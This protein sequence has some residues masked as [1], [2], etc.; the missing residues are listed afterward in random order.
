MIEPAI[1]HPQKAAIEIL[2]DRLGLP[3]AQS[4][5]D[6]EFEVAE[7][8]ELPRYLALYQEVQGEDDLRFVLADIIIQAFEDS[9]FELSENVDWLTFLSFLA[10][11]IDIHGWQIWYWASWE[12]ELEDAWRV[13]PFMRALCETHFVD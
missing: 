10:D 13:S 6:W 9:D 12:V 2:A 8:F 5:Q 4:Q 11:R 3:K 1:R 7:A